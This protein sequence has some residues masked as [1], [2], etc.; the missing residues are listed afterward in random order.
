M[1]PTNIALGVIG[2]RKPPHHD[3]VLIPIEV[4]VRFSITN[5]VLIKTDKEGLLTRQM[6]C[7]YSVKYHNKIKKGK[8][9][10]SWLKSTVFYSENDEQLTFFPVVHSM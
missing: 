8:T 6:K 2:T 7:K 4:D 9:Q 1:T 3:K 5:S 10:I